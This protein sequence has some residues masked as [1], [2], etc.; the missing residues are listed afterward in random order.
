MEKNT[1]FLFILRDVLNTADHNE[2][3]TT[4]GG[5]EFRRE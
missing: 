2:A 1:P 3:S 5:A 4:R